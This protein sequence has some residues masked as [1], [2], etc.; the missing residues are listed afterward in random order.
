MHFR[1]FSSEQPFRSATCDAYMCNDL[2]VRSN[3]SLDELY[4]CK[5]KSRLFHYNYAK[6]H[7]GI[8]LEW[9]RKKHSHVSFSFSLVYAIFMY[10][11]VFKRNARSNWVSRGSVWSTQV[12]KRLKKMSLGPDTSVECVKPHT[13]IR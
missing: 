1:Y 10:T 4:I 2:R 6:C 7:T 8:P 13:N 5:A 3:A 11:Y 12:I 9:S